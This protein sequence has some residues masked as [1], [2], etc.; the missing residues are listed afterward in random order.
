MIHNMEMLLLQE[1][2]SPS[3]KKLLSQWLIANTTGSKRLR[4]RTPERWTVGDKTGTGGL[5]TTNDIAIF[6][7]P[8]RKPI[9]VVA[10]LTE[11]NAPLS[12]RNGALAP[13]GQLITTALN[14]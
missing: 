7:P 13:V 9:L 12:Q 14:F 2:L 8:G 3:S 5:G 10:Y 1:R 6:W 4:A 11:S